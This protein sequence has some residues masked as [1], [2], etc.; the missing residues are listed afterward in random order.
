MIQYVS[1]TI[2]EEQD[3]VWSYNKQYFG[4]FYIGRSF[5]ILPTE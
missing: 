2:I 5:I 3:K 4:H 1:I